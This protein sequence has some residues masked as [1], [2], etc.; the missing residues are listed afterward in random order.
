MSPQKLAVAMVL[1]SAA[2]NSTSGLLLRNLEAAS[3]WQA[4][5][6]RGL[7]LAAAILA[8]M[9][10]QHRGGALGEFRRIGLLGLL[11]GAF[12]GATLVFFVLALSHTTV[13]NTVFTMSATPFFTAL[14]AWLVLGERVGGATAV[15]I[16]AALGGIALMVGGA[17]AAGSAF[18]N[19]M[20]I[21]TALCFAGFVV[22]LRK[23][24][25]FDMLPAIAV[26]ALISALAAAFMIE[27]GYRLSG[28]DLGLCLLWGAVISGPAH[29][30]F[31][32]ASRALSGAELTLLVLLEFIL[33]P[34]WVW[35]FVAE[36]PATLTLVGGAVVL[37]AV[38]GHALAALAKRN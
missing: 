9:V 18:G 28:R 35:L 37:T 16:A 11:G 10:W 14:L 5:F 21:L 33:A 2:I 15:A 22:V 38:G 24:R 36:V 29:V 17:A 20:A 8:I 4:V 6:W 19:A 3:D 1:A 31:V 26:G 27:D 32:K 34:L 13:A 25:G 30:L 12:Y 23:G 7:S